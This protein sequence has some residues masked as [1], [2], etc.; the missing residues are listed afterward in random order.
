MSLA[1]VLVPIAVAAISTPLAAQEWVRLP[2]KNREIAIDGHRV[3]VVV[4][5]EIKFTDGPAS[6]IIAQLRAYAR[7]DD[8]QDKAPALLRAFAERKSDC[9]TRWSFPNLSPVTIWGGKLKVS[10]QVRVEQWLCAGPLKTYLARETADFT[11]AL[12]PVN[13]V[14]EVIVDAELEHFDLGKSLLGGIGHELRDVISGL[15]NKVY[16]EDMKF[17]FPEEIASITRNSRRP[18]SGTRV[19]ARGELFMEAQATIRASDMTKILSLVTKQ[20]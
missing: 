1:F 5:P 15:L 16:S 4:R 6:N 17:K 3:K 12:Y 2:E 20:N 8:L 7:L 13:K 14:K 11:I 19:A 10:G 9:G 18:S